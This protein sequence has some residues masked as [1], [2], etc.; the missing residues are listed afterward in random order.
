MIR[1]FITRKLPEIARRTLGNGFVIDG[2]SENS[3]LPAA[4]LARAVR[5]YDAILSMANDT[6]DRSAIGEPGPLKVISNYASGL[7]NIDLAHAR[8]V[9]ITVYNTPDV[10]TESTA[11][12]TFALLLS[13]IRSIGPAHRFVVENRWSSWDPYLFV[14]E[15][16]FGKTLGIVG[17]GRIGQAVARRAVGFGVEILYANP[18]HKPI[19][20]RLR[21]QVA[22]VSLAELLSRSDYISLHVPLNPGT[23]G[24]IDRHSFARMTRAPVL[25]NTARGGVVDTDDL[26]E[27]LRSGTIRG[28]AL[29]VC[30]PEPIP[31]DHPL[32]GF[33]NC[34]LTPHIGT[35]TEAAR[36]KMAEL[37]AR[38][39]VTHFA[40]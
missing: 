15:E 18:S 27:A 29:D 30:D 4:E 22:R 23:K 34:L 28:A 33:D 14:G 38:N 17:F 9:G 40:R 10:V 7:D 37:A 2:N 3:A 31:V 25:V 11:D 6:L 13:L 19:E 5:E 35:A 8:A 36:S 39:I 16:L 26:V 32:L 20:G 24:L 21:D 1:V 12:H